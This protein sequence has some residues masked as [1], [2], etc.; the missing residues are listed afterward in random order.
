MRALSRLCILI[1]LTA[2]GGATPVRAMS[3][4]P[5]SETLFTQIERADTVV[6][7]RLRAAEPGALI[8]SGEQVLRGGTGAELR[9]VL[10]DGQAMGGL[11]PRSRYLLMLNRVADGSFTL[12]LEGL[13]ILRVADADLPETLDAVRAWVRDREDPV[14]ARAT[15]VTFASARSAFIQ[16]SA[17]MGLTHLQLMDRPALQLLVNQ[18]AAG[19]VV[20]PEARQMIVRFVGVMGATEHQGFLV[21]RIRDTAE[22]S[23]LREAALF[24]LDFMDPGAARALAPDIERTGTPALRALMRSLLP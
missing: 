20:E 8:F 24:A 22:T 13:S 11:T 10:P 9:V 1:L 18:L 6:L 3:V 14:S 12:P 19:R 16:R 15:L 7:A 2:V 23:E 17:I 21:A 4:A 5:G